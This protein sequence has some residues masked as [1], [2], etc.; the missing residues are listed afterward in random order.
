MGWGLFLLNN[1]EVI[2]RNAQFYLEVPDEGLAEGSLRVVEKGETI[3][4][5]GLGL[6]TQDHDVPHHALRGLHGACGLSVAAPGDL[7]N[8]DE[9]GHRALGRPGEV[10]DEPARFPERIAATF[11]S[12]FLAARYSE[13]GL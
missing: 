11:F 6:T 2:E 4:R 9:R 12:A 7:T 5:I 1:K 13:R 8:L 3:L 10:L